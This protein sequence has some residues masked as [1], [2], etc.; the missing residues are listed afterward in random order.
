MPTVDVRE[1]EQSFVIHFGGEFTRINAYTLASTLVNIADAARAANSVLNPGYEIEIVV[2]ALESG[3]FR[4]RVRALYRH[5]GNLFSNQAANAIVLGVIGNFVYQHTLAP[6]QS[7]S[8]IVNTDEVVIE[9]GDTRILVP[10]QIHEATVQVETIPRF[11]RG[12][13]EALR[14]IADDPQVTSIGLDSGVPRP[15]SERIPPIQIPRERFAT[16]PDELEEDVRPSREVIETTELAIV[17]AILERSRRRW[18][19]VWHGVRIAAPVTD[20]AFY[21]D[22]IAHRITIAPGDILRVRLRLRQRR[23]DVIGIFVNEAYEV[24]E[25]LEHLPRVTFTGQQLD[26]L[27][28]SVDEPQNE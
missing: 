3:S 8:V 6:D 9:Q 1:F 14:A 23:D 7:I 27:A 17:R 24:I 2:E 11:R 13:G 5:G 12:V 19:F 26:G 25:V 4:T 10:R 21:D 20:S 22:F 15:T 16:I 18:E 28:E